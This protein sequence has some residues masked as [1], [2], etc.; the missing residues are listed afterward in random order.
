MLINKEE[1]DFN[2]KRKVRNALFPLQLKWGEGIS[3]V[4]HNKNWW[5][6]LS[7]TPFY[8]EVQKDGLPL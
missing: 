4:I 6:K 7:A 8:W 1:S 2:F 5:E 3:T